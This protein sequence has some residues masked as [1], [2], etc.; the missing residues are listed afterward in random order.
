M[1]IKRREAKLARESYSFPEGTINWKEVEPDPES[2]Y[3]TTDH[4]NEAMALY[5]KNNFPK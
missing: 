3:A 4:F 5:K 2:G 1:S